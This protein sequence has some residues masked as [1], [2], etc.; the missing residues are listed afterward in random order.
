MKRLL[1]FAGLLTL[2]LCS[3]AWGDEAHQVITQLAIYGLP[4]K[5]QPFYYRYRQQLVDHAADLNAKAKTDPNEAA[6][7]FIAM[8]HYGLNNFARL[9]RDWDG[10]VAKYSAD[11]LRRYGTAPWA[12][13]EAID[14]LAI[15]F[16]NQNV[17][18]ILRY[19]DELA[20]YGADLHVPLR[21]SGAAV[22]KLSKSDNL[23]G[24]WEDELVNKNIARFRLYDGETKKGF[25]NPSAAVWQMARESYDMVTTVTELEAEVSREIPAKEK[26]AYSYN[27]GKAVRHY[28]DAFG[29]AYF[30]KVGGIIA[31]RFKTAPDAVALFWL[32]AWEK[33][34]K[35]NLDKLMEPEFSKDDKRDL[36]VELLA[37]A[38]GRLVDNNVLLAL[39]KGGAPATEAPAEEATPAAEK[40]AEVAPAETSAPEAPA[41]KAKKEKKKKKDAAAPPAGEFDTPKEKTASDDDQ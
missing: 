27:L 21:T 11:T 28:S 2:P 26:Y 31:F 39:R 17:D 30:K 10:A 35:P 16:Q 8:D 5:M 25:D 24:L 7:Q 14:N 38:N 40:P 18:E 9:P 3:F 29:D 37:R 12:V 20:F 22:K 4:A 6:R 23:I 13:L 32:T 19:S 41:G 36:S 33:G 34:G 1:L 15:A